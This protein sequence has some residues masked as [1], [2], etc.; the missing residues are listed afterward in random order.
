MPLDIQLIKCI[1]NFPGIQSVWNPKSCNEKECNTS[2]LVP[3]KPHNSFILML[4]YHSSISVELVCSSN[5]TLSF[6]YHCEAAKIITTSYQSLPRSSYV[7]PPDVKPKVIKNKIGEPSQK[8]SKESITFTSIFQDIRS[9]PLPNAHITARAITKG[10]SKP[11]SMVSSNPS[12]M[13]LEQFPA[14]SITMRP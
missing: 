10:P 13:R 6:Q 14:L 1:I 7:I 12:T 2:E 8:I 4:A 5:I 3:Q 9:I 11:I